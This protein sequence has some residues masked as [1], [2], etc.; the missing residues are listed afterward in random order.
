MTQVCIVGVGLIGGSLGLALR[1]VRRSGKRL[2][3][4][5]GFGRSKKN[6]EKAKRRGALDSFST[7]PARALSTADLVVLCVPVQNIVPIARKALPFLKKGAVITDVG[8]VK[9]EV[10]SGMRRLLKGRK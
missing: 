7:S 10:V 5:I 6:L 2:Y 8:S 9:G 3:K 1:R 4:V